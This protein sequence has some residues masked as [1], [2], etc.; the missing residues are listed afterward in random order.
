MKINLSYVAVCERETGEV[1]LLAQVSHL[2]GGGDCAK[3]A[4][5]HDLIRG[6][7]AEG[8]A[9][10]EKYSHA[11]VVIDNVERAAYEFPD[12]KVEEEKR[13][14]LELDQARKAAADAAA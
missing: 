14:A 9:L 6:S 11:L 2:T 4:H 7:T 12:P 1:S 10:R 3:V 5:A 13:L 8:F